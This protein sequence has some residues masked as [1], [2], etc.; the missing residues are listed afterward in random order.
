ML[1]DTSLK[2]DPEIVTPL[3]FKNGKK[4]CTTYAVYGGVGRER[5]TI[6]AKRT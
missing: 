1:P 6:I 3:A 5:A 4:A 2:F